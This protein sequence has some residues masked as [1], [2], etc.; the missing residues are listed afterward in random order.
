M[1]DFTI[2][3]LLT[4]IMRKFAEAIMG[5]DGC[6]CSQITF[7]LNQSKIQKTSVKILYQIVLLLYLL[8]YYTKI[9]YTCKYDV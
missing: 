8:H 9:S 6:E 3:C 5:S 2:G 1:I 7:T 4:V